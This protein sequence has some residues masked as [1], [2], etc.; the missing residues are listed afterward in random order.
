MSILFVCFSF[1]SVAN[2]SFY[3]KKYDVDKEVIQL[4]IVTPTTKARVLH[5][6]GHVIYPVNGAN[7]VNNFI[8]KIK[9]PCTKLAT[10]TSVLWATDKYP[11]MEAEIPR[12]TCTR[13]S[14]HSSIMFF[15]KNK[16][17]W[18][19][20][21]KNTLW[22]TAVEL[23][24]FNKY[25]V[26]QNLYAVLLTNKTAFVDGDFDKLKSNFILCPSKKIFNI[27][28]SEHAETLFKEALYF[29]KHQQLK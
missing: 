27:I 26:Y 6:I 24:N 10:K 5:K 16:Q 29:K 22:R 1:P 12:Q 23:S 9:I 28:P 8:L 11:I 19:N 7:L 13:K 25:T 2:E 18:I 4:V 15:Y 17:C 21:N 3:F 14:R 20:V